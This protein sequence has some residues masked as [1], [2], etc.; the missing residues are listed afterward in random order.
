MTIKLLEFKVITG[1]L[2]VLTG[3]RVG[4]GSEALEIGGM[5]NPIVRDPYTNEPY[6]PGSSIK[7]KMR[8]LLEWREGKMKNDGSPCDCGSPDCYICRIFGVSA[9]RERK[10]GPTRLIVRDARVSPSFLRAMQ[11][12]K[13]FASEQIV[14]GDG[15][16]SP[17]S[18]VARR[19]LASFLVE[20]KSENFINRITAMA[21]PRRLERV[22]AGTV[23]Q[24]EMTY[25][26]FAM[27]GDNGETDRRLLPKV[28]E[29]IKALEN[30]ALGGYGSRGCGRVRIENLK[31]DGEPWE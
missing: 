16:V 19:A 18:L 7:G 23:F 24:L 12:K 9:E 13:F 11:A 21:N 6:I 2:V 3:L 15:D 4:A 28:K 26:V 29:A 20:A 10:T 1:D 27:N 17:E 8:S 5:D 31:L 22:P 30:D 14:K 25:R